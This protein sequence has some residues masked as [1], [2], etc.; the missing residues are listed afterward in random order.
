MIADWLEELGLE[1]NE[2]SDGEEALDKAGGSGS[3]TIGS[4]PK[5][6]ESR[7]ELILLNT[8]LPGFSAEEVM[9][10]LRNS[11]ETEGVP[12]ILISA[13]TEKEIHTRF[14]DYETLGTLRK[15]IR[16]ADLLDLLAEIFP[17]EEYEEGA[18]TTFGGENEGQSAEQR[19]A[20]DIASTNEP[21][22]LLKNLEEK[23]LPRWRDIGTTMFV[24]DIE[25]FA[26]EL[27]SLAETHSY[28]RLG[29]YADSLLRAAE[30]FDVEKLTKLAEQ[31]E[32]KVRE[33]K[34]GLGS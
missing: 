2:A 24:D 28:E 6:A 19:L 32:E 31:F 5:A 20:A 30:S 1:P 23:Y 10:K 18:G 7:P 34:G 4:E 22:E 9:E 27:K 3:E 25:Q 14:A 16:Y 21:E 12:I 15:P 8:G 29:S 26:E 33:L 13:L 17:I 11:E